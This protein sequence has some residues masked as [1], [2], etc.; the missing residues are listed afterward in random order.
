M[1]WYA[2]K[3]LLALALHLQMHFLHSCFNFWHVAPGLSYCKL[4]IN[5]LSLAVLFYSPIHYPPSQFL[6]LWNVA[7]KCWNVWNNIWKDIKVRRIINF[8]IEYNKTTKNTRHLYILT[9]TRGG[10]RL[11]IIEKQ[12]WSEGVN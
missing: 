9:I 4:K 3:V 12:D 5:K 11:G 8:I 1:I 2:E 7:V 6:F 10:V